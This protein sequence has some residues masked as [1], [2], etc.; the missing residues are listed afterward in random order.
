MHTLI[1]QYEETTNPITPPIPTDPHIQKLLTE[2]SHI[3]ET[4]TS[5]PPPRNHDH[6]IPVTPKAPPVNVRPYRYPHYQKQIMADLIAEML[7]DGLIKP[8][9][10][11]YSSPVL[12]VR[13]KDGC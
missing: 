5:L 4:P 3:F 8:S 7:K 12:L 13:K 6:H 2:Y 11:P 9:H 1:F 10:S